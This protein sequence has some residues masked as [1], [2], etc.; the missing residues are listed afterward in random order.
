[1]HPIIEERLPELRELCRRYHVARLEMFGS[2]VKENFDPAGS[3]LDFVLE[4]LP[5]AKEFYPDVYFDLKA[6]LEALF[7]RPVDLVMQ[8]AIRNPY[9]QAELEETKV[10]VY[11]A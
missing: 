3:D 5:E 4:Y 9:F 10:P 2:A 11:A 7:N 6:E 8:T 1:M